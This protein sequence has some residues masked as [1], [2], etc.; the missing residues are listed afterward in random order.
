ML[1]GALC[2]APLSA[3]ESLGVYS[4]WAAFRDDRPARCY[5]IAQ[6]QRERE[7]KPFAS[8]ANYPARGIQR[9]VH[10]RLSRPVREGASVRLYV[11]SRRFDLAANAHNAWATDSRM[12]A[13]IVAAMRS[14]STMRVSTAD[15][16][17][18]R[19]VDRYEL[20]GAATAIDAATV[21][22]A[23]GRRES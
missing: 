10:I 13:A 1:L 4:S 20:S 11:G 23:Q 15:T 17:G 5:A 22:C 21:G 19:F 14:A 18:V 16:G 12:D 3:K 9:Q 2:G 8:I 7:S 6:P